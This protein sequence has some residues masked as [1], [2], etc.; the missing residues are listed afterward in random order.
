MANI[1][2]IDGKNG[3][4]YKITVTKGRDS[5]GKQLR[6]YMTWTPDRPMTERQ[7]Q[8]AVERAAA[9]FERDIELGFQLDNR[10]TFA[11]YADYVIELKERSGAK[12]RTTERYRELL[13]RINPAIGHIKLVELRPQHLN[14]FLQESERTGHCQHRR[15]GHRESGYSCA[16]EGG[17]PDPRQARGAFRHLS[18]DHNLGL[19]GKNGRPSHGG[20]HSTGAGQGRKA[21]VHG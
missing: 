10:Q 19:S 20:G 13:E 15:Q 16:F 8:K 21:A 12:Y 11:E 4:S 9:D 1:R 7:M 18:N 5:S 6:H 14:A 17:A 2:T 3:V